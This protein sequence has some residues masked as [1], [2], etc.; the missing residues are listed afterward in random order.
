[1]VLCMKTTIDMPDEIMAR[2]RRAMAKRHVTFRELVVDALQTSLRD[3]SPPFVLRD[4]AAGVSRSRQ[5]GVSSE[6]INRAI[7]EQRERPEP[8]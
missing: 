2:A 3:D 8:R 4:A 1:M 5:A 6:A 7:D